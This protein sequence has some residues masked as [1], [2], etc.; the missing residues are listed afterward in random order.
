MHC[1]C[2]GIRQIWLEIW[3]EPDLARFLKYGRIPN[4]SEAISSTTLVINNIE[5][6]QTKHKYRHI[7]KELRYHLWFLPPC[8]YLCQMSIQQRLGRQWDEV[9]RMP[10]GRADQK[11]S[12]EHMAPDDWVEKTAAEWFLLQKQTAAFVS[13]KLT[14]FSITNEHK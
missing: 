5:Y 7:R 1:I 3:P 2:T 8:Q 6:S 12:D 14:V 11:H 4:L 13:E 10:H 9:R